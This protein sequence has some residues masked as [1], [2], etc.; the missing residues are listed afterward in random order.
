MA[1]FDTVLKVDLAGTFNSVRIAASVMSRLEPMSEDGDR[2]AIVLTASRTGLHGDVGQ[3]AYSAL[4]YELL[5]NGYYN[6]ALIPIDG[7]AAH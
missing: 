5:T 6:G 1:L 4:A 7:G 2:G 3:S